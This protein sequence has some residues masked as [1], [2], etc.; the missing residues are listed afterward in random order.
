MCHSLVI[1]T[2]TVG[3]KFLLFIR[4]SAHGALLQQPERAETVAVLAVD[5]RERPEGEIAPAPIIFLGDL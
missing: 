4:H 5:C 2:R 3:N 1:G